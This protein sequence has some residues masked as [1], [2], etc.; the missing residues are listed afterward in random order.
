M[1]T[2][3]TRLNYFNGKE[4]AQS[5]TTSLLKNHKGST[6]FKASL[7]MKKVKKV[8]KPKKVK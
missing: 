1:N 2:I 4:N 7:K 3:K 5:N 8:K 6:I